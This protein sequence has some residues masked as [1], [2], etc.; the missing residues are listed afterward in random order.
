MKLIKTNIINNMKKYI[1]LILAIY[2]N[3]CDRAIYVNCNNNIDFNYYQN[4]GFGK[5]YIEENC[6]KFKEL[7]IYRFGIGVHPITGKKF[8]EKTEK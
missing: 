1:F 6:R 2:L 4:L 5:E 7:G 8:N 3:S